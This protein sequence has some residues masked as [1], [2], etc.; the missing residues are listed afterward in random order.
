MYDFISIGIIA[1]N[2]GKVI[3]TTLS[4]L[5][6]QTYP[7]D[8]VEIIF[9]DGNSTDDSVQQVKNTLEGKVKYKIINERDIENPK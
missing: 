8:K 3:A 2:E 1:R 5:L 4:Y 9:V 6:K 7:L